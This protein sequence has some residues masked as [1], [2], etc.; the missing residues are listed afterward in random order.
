V[1]TKDQ[2][3][4]D[5]IVYGPVA[6]W[7]LG[8]S[9]GI[10]LLSTKGKT[11]SFDCLYC[12]LGRTV[13]PLAE[14]RE[15]VPL[16]RLTSELDRIGSVKA[17]Y[18]TFSGVGEPTLASNLGPAIETARRILRLPVAVLSNSSLMPDEGVRRQLALA[19]VVVVKLDAPSEDIFRLVNRPLTPYSLRKILEGIK[20]FSRQYKGEWAL[21]M[22]FIRENRGC[23][24][25]MAELA[26]EL[27]PD[28]VQINTPLRECSVDPLPP[29]DIAA[30]KDEF[31]GLRKVVT[32]YE[33]HR[34]Q[35]VPLNLTETLRRRPIEKSRQEGERHGSSGH[36]VE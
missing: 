16:A 7:R 23:A 25:R 5:G 17:D 22:M 18:A 6:S 10:D 3:T 34:P 11:C 8:R 21:Q 15:F 19:D 32:V 9:L 20:C 24:A 33:A 12:Q 1:L 30:I 13:H 26:A 4:I 36:N 31:K 27:S 2:H 35:V 28:E 29:E 14:R